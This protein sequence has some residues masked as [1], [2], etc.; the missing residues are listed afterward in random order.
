MKNT[1]LI[2]VIVILINSV[3][4]LSFL[5][6]ENKDQQQ[7]INN[8]IRKDVGV[9][10]NIENTV[11]T[12][13]NEIYN[14]DMRLDH[15]SVQEEMRD[16]ASKDI[17]NLCHTAN[18]NEYIYRGN[19]L[20]MCFRRP[21]NFL[22]TNKVQINLEDIK[23]Y[24]PKYPLDIQRLYNKDSA[25]G[26]SYDMYEYD[27]DA[28]YF[29]NIDY[30]EELLRK[31]YI[32]KSYYEKID[33][34]GDRHVF[35]VYNSFDWDMFVNPFMITNDNFLF[36]S[37]LLSKRLDN[38]RPGFISRLAISKK[39]K[40]VRLATYIPFGDRLVGIVYEYHVKNNFNPESAKKIVEQENDKILQSVISR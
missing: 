1:I 39:H 3:A 33:S 40:R 18:N 30:A 9:D 23:K 2:I 10:S 13:S 14:Q 26:R 15:E 28:Q 25:N 31:I 5:L 35:I 16:G 12:L 22:Y 27:E 6:W 36:D 34:S 7:T 21:D 24:T 19:Q 29:D 32:T 38:I 8:Q 37:N 17:L 11:D 20:V 4:I